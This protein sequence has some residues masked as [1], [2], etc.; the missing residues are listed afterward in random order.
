M[1]VNVGVPAGGG[2]AMSS[3]AIYGFMTNIAEALSSELGQVKGTTGA[4]GRTY[5]PQLII[6]A[7]APKPAR[8]VKKTI[9]YSVTTYVG[10]NK[11]SEALSK[12]WKLSKDGTYRIARHTKRSKLVFLDIRGIQYAWRMRTEQYTKLQK[13][14]SNLGIKEAKKGDLDLVYG[15]SFPRPPKVGVIVAGEGGTD[16]LS[17]FC[18]PQKLDNLPE[19]W[20]LIDPGNYA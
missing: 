16:T 14:A 13:Y 7:D 9:D 18:E 2:G 1:G 19:S 20:F 12:G 15:P 4:G 5:I 8:V 3:V 10:H 17:T 11:L 6:G